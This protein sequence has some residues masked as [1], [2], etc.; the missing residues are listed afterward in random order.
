M[1]S[2]MMADVGT[3]SPGGVPMEREVA[4]RT[5]S[6][7]M[8][9]RVRARARVWARVRVRVRARARVMVIVRVRVWPL[10]PSPSEGVRRLSDRDRDPALQT[11][12]ASLFAA[13]IEPSR[14][15]FGLGLRVSVGGS[16]SGF[17][18]CSGGLQA[19]SFGD[20]HS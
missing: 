10:V 6:E 16:A 8:N 1:V 14:G 17:K 18:D 9:V 13:G 7:E 5:P 19:S 2:S 11:S 15:R 12:I 4:M 3:Q 20:M